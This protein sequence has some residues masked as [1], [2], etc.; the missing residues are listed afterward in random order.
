MQP[1]DNLLVVVERGGTLPAWVARC[2][3]RV[4]DLW[5]VACGPDDDSR[6][7]VERIVQRLAVLEESNERLGLAVVVTAMGDHSSDQKEARRSLSIALLEHMERQGSGRMVFLTDD[8]LSSEGRVDILSLAS[9][10]AQSLGTPQV[11]ITIR[12]AGSSEESLVEE[13]FP[14]RTASE[15]RTSKRPPRSGRHAKAASVSEPA[16]CA[17]SQRP[18][19][20]RSI[21]PG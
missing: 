19:R 7:L 13:L 20:R 9:S 8:A 21:V 15:R 6:A 12:F 10:L 3:E 17:E 5:V 1:Q 11:S 4:A 2:H 18:S 14:H 16:E